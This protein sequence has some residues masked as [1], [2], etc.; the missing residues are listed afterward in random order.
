MGRTQSRLPKES[1]E[2]PSAE[3]ADEMGVDPK[4]VRYIHH[5]PA[6]GRDQEGIKSIAE[7]PPGRLSRRIEWRGC[8]GSAT[9]S[10]SPSQ[11]ETCTDR[12]LG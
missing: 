4:N 8:V 12:K 10:S 5:P 9:V 6:Y 11:Q 1:K 3:D 2:H 7:T